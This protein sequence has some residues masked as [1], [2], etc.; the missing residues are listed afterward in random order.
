MVHQQKSVLAPQNEIVFL[1]FVT[2][3]QAMSVRL[4]DEK[5]AQV[6]HSCQNLNGKKS[7]LTQEVSSVIGNADVKLEIDNTTAIAY[8][9][10]I[11]GTK[12]REC[13]ELA[14]ELWE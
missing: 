14:K 8:I 9:N 6:K 3:S 5:S 10:Q 1:G 13:N 2:N 4:T 7:P 12:S 11:G